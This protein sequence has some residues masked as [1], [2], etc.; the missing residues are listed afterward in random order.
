[1][2][3]AIH[4]VK[5]VDSQCGCLL[6]L[7]AIRYHRCDCYSCYSCYKNAIQKNAIQK[8]T[9]EIQSTKYSKI[10][11]NPS[12]APEKT[13]VSQ[14]ENPTNPTNPT[15]RTQYNTLRGRQKKKKDKE[16]RYAVWQAENENKPQSSTIPPSQ[17][18]LP[19]NPSH[20]SPEAAT[21]AIQPK[22]ITKKSSKTDRQ[23][24]KRHNTSKLAEKKTP[25]YRIPVPINPI[26]VNPINHLPHC[27]FTPSA[28]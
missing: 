1:M 27:Q 14:P 25:P 18:L 15:Q 3:D 12:V 22:R 7:A 6:Q 23:Y 4:G 28:N 5:H 16:E 8:D 19:S 24:E 17:T 2:L 26:Q 21:T 10:T 13:A 9:I 20:D 11:P